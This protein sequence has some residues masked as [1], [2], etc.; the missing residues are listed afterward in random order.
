MGDF[1]AYY[2]VSTDKQGAQGLGMDAQREAVA[3]FIGQR[4]QIVGEYTEVESGRKNNRPQLLAALEE[5]KARRA[6]LVIAKLDRLARNVYFISGLMESKVDFQA[7]DMPDANRLTIHVLA[8]VAE[9]EREMIS[10]RTKA[11]LAQAKARGTKLGNPNAAQAAAIGRAA[12]VIPQPP[13]K[14]RTLICDRHASGASLR[15]I[16]RELNQLGIKTPKGSQWYAC[17]VERQ[18]ARDRRG[19]AAL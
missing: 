9:H 6:T 14:V 11:A 7:V 4:G 19:E 12:I 16:A 8:A 1:I 17:T 13:P 18:I 2:R 3:R 5:C 15:E 10:Q